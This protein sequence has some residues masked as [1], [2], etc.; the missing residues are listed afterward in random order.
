MSIEKIIMAL[1]AVAI[2]MAIGMIGYAFYIM[3][4]FTGG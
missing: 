3:L 2:C 4:K 1:G